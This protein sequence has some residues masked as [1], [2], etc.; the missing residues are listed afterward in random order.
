MPR[1]LAGFPRASPG[2]PSPACSQTLIGQTRPGFPPEAG[3]GLEA[4]GRAHPRARSARN[5]ILRLTPTTATLVG[6]NAAKWKLLE[7]QVLA[8]R[9]TAGA[10]GDEARLRALA[11]EL[12]VVLMAEEAGVVPRRRRQ[13]HGDGGSAP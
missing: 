10:P 5:T 12:G 3:D 7:Q 8:R 11:A 9:R 1:R 2:L 6:E 4:A 13:P